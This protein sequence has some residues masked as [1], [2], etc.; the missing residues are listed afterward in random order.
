MIHYLFEDTVKD[1]EKRY[2]SIIRGVRFIT[3]FVYWN[4]FGKLQFRWL[5]SKFN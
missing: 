3:T 1:G 5:G 4:Y 2:G